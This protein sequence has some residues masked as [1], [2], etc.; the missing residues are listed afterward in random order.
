[1]DIEQV[2]KLLSIPGNKV[3]RE[4]WMKDTIFLRFFE[5]WEYKD[6]SGISYYMHY[7]EPY[8][9]Y[10]RTNC[11]GDTFLTECL[12]DKEDLEATD[13]IELSDNQLENWRNRLKSNP[14]IFKGYPTGPTGPQG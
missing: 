5:S 6:G 7:D 11:G 10:G 13:W 14:P 3:S 4:K 9:N 8:R 2:V 12:S 1:M